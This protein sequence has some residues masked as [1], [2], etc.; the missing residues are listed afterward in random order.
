MYSGTELDIFFLHKG[1]R[2]GIE[3]KYNEAPAGTKSMRTALETL[4]L[5][6]YQGKQSYPAHDNISILPVRDFAAIWNQ[7]RQN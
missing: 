3:F 7:L 1:R 5:D 4:N 6:L 2:Y